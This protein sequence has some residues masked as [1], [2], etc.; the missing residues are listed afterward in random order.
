MAAAVGGILFQITF[1]SLTQ[2]CL[3]PRDIRM[4]F[5][6]NILICSWVV[7]GWWA[8]TVFVY[9]VFLLCIQY[10]DWWYLY[11]TYGALFVSILWT[12][13]SAFNPNN[14]RVV[15]IRLFR[16]YWKGWHIFL[17][18]TEKQCKVGLWQEHFHW[19]CKNI[20]I[21]ILCLTFHISVRTWKT[22]LGWEM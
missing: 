8:Y 13:R 10:Q 15:E 18:R 2:Q 12:F 17:N 1:S 21:Y 14:E 7:W 16:S 3:C 5:F 11:R 9:H 19:V 22:K 6:G 20:N 4:I